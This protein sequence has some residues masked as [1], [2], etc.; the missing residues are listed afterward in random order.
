MNHRKKT[1][2]IIAI[3]LGA[4]LASVLINLTISLIQKASYPKKYEE[5]VEK[6]ASEYNVPEYII[7]AVINTESGFD[8]KAESSAGAFG[9]M[10]M[11]EST[12]YYIASD[13][14]LD[15]EAEFDDL[16]N[17]D[18]AI[19]YG[20]YYL[21]YLFDKFNN[22]NVVFAAYNAGE[23]NVSEWLSD[24]QYSKDGETLKKIPIKETRNYVKKVNRAVSYYKDTYYRNGV[25]VK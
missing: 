8:T 10:Q 7:Y 1:I 21:R 12:F 3:I 13:E 14:H 23:G 9:L 6:Y 24:P 18:T 15:E 16:S 11:M 19:R 20:T 2:I 22:W 17:P 25:S 4:I 5:Y